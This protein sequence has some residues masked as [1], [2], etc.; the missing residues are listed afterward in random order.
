[1]KHV[2][3]WLL[4]ILFVGLGLLYL[5][6]SAS[7]AWVSG[8]P[9]GAYSHAWTQR[10]LVHFGYAVSCMV[11]AVMI[12]VALGKNFSLGASRFKYVWVIIVLVSLLSPHLRA[13]LLVDKCLDSGGVWDNSRF[14]CRYDPAR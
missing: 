9:P 11:S 10:A 14:E 4:V 3:R 8:G 13:F 6:S 2:I 1:M 5:N 7:S 12:F